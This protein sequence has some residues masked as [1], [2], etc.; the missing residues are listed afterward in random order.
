MRMSHYYL[1]L[2]LALAP[3]LVATAYLGL[4]YDGSQKHLGAGLL[5]S[6]LCVATN[7]V[8]ILFM[9]VTGRV[10]KAAMRARPL[11]PEFLAELNLFFE[12]KRAYPLALFSAMAAVVAAVLGYGEFIGVPSAVHILFGLLAVLLNLYTIPV[13]LG[14]L[15]DNMRLLDSASRELDRLD[16]EIGPAPPEA[17]EIDWSY[18][19]STRWLVFGL[20]AW[21]PYVYWGF[22]VWRGDF[23]SV[24]PLFPLL[25]A[26]VSVLGLVRAWYARGS[27]PVG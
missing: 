14:T 15:R 7:T 22:V 6:V 12:R 10:L 16:H 13:A 11:P 5:T 25:T 27:Q 18:G 24:S 21:L 23:T 17:G 20:S 4:E 1:A 3:A 9:I 8:F 19:P 2:A 26:P